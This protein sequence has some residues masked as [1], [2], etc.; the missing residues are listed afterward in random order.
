MKTINLTLLLTAIALFFFQATQAQNIT[1]I[2]GGGNLSGENVPDSIG[3]VTPFC[4]VYDTAGNLYVTDA[5]HNVIRKITAATGLINTIAGTGTGGF[6]GDGGDATAA[7]LNFPSYITIDNTGNIF[8]SDGSNHRVRKIDLSGIITTIAGNGTTSYNG[9]G[10]AA[11]TAQL[12]PFGLAFNSSGDL[13]VSDRINCRIRKISGGVI[14]TIAG[15]GAF[16]YSGDG[17]QATDAK[18]WGPWDLTID[19]YGNILFIDADNF[20]IRKIT[21]AGIIS[22]IAGN[23]SVST[24]SDGATAATA[25]VSS[26]GAGIVADT[27]GNVY[28]SEYNKIRKI[29][30]SGILRTAAAQYYSTGY[31]GDGGPATAA[32]FSDPQ[33]LVFDRHGNLVLA[34][35]Y[36]YVVRNINP[37]GIVHTIAGNNFPEFSGDK[38]DQMNATMAPRK[39]RFDTAGNLYFAD[40]VFQTIR[41]ISPSG[42]VT[43]VAG[44][45]ATAGYYNQDGDKAILAALANYLSV[46]PD[47]QGNLYIADRTT[48][49]I[50]KVDNAGIIHTVAGNGTAGYY[51]DGGPATNAL[52]KGVD[53]IEADS[54]GNV[55]FSDPGNSRIRKISTT[56][57]ITT[58]A[59]NGTLG[60]T[61]DGGPATAARIYYPR[62]IAIDK[63]GNLYFAD[64]TAQIRRVSPSGIITTIAGTGVAGY[65]GDGGPATAANITYGD[66]SFDKQ[67]NLLIC[68]HNNV[69]R[70][71]DTSGIITTVAGTGTAGFSGDGGPATNAL[72]K[73][74]YGAQGD[75]WGNIYVADDSNGRIRFIC[76][77]DTIISSIGITASATTIC[78][79]STVTF[80]SADTNAGATPVYQWKLNGSNISGATNATYT[81]TTLANGDTVWVEITG[82][83]PAPCAANN[84]AGSNQVG[85]VVHALSP[86]PTVTSVVAS[87]DAVSFAGQPITFTATYTGGGSTPAFQWYKNGVAISGATTNPYISTSVANGDNITVTIH[88]SNLCAFPDSGTSTAAIMGLGVGQA[89]SNQNQFQIMP[90]PN[91]GS[92]TVKGEFPGNSEC[93]IEITDPIGKVVFIQTATIVHQVLN[94]TIKL[95]STLLSGLYFIS[96]KSKSS[97]DVRRFMKL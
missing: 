26:T 86:T 74:G 14:E 31:S 41:K 84:T 87:P 47:R 54:A 90:N 40:N 77:H 44:Y 8:F 38:G 46:A 94:Q 21:P 36:N 65:S 23:G 2:A 45:G 33:G 7:V 9:D 53:D 58:F 11:T 95:D 13:I 34:D 60:S 17:G 79:G 82:N 10:I 83:N 70:K 43:R 81:S 91:S 56:G 42:K 76:A 29:D 51:G 80:T 61:G 57:I 88:T 24:A 6:S 59:G 12:D 85:M 19:R 50:R 72:L 55:Y 63:H 39:I 22:T 49:R 28:F 71:I 78:A 48:F 73:T 3:Q 20:R 97:V 25:A 52:I 16:G 75:R 67:G 30:G 27:S 89:I 96:I 64:D 68:Q 62:E 15:T 37:S 93:I 18:I 32:F 66:L 4:M 69:I 92:F 5:V 35:Q 1:T